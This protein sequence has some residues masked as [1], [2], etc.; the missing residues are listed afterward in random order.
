MPHNKP[1]KRRNG[2]G[3]RTVSNVT[4]RNQYALV[5]RL[6]FDMKYMKTLINAEMHIHTVFQSD[7]QVDN[8]G[9][10][11]SL[12]DVP[13]GDQGNFRT[14]ISILPRFQSINITIQ[15]NIT[16]NAPEND[17][18]RLMLF[19]YWGEGTDALP[20]VEVGDVLVDSQPYSY[21]NKDNTGRRGDRDRRIEVH[22][23]KFFQLD[24]TTR[25]NATF[26]W[27]IKVN[28]PEKKI[29]DHIKFRD[30]MTDPPAS[31]GFFLLIIS[32]NGVAAE[33]ATMTFNSNMKFYDN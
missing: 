16:G 33:H 21:L 32:D 10:V 11:F 25:T 14:G 27:N 18:I 5:N 20:L 23:S 29:K 9:A 30:S 26:K 8:A 31:G 15:K 4:Y 6:N 2:N 17:V 22:K 1:Y 12:N 24:K 7:A 13:V 28:G 3:N 19:R